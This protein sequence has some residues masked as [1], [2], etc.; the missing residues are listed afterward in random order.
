MGARSIFQMASQTPRHT[1]ESF[2]QP[3]ERPTV[4]WLCVHMP[5]GVNPDHLTMVG[6]LGAAVVF[7]GYLLSSRDPLFLWLANFGLILHWFGDSLDG[8][9]ARFR[10]IERPKYGYFLDHTTDVLGEVMI[11]LGLGLSSFVRFETACLALIVYLMLSILAFV[12]AQVSGVLEV[13]F[14][15]IGGTELRIGIFALNVLMFLAPP[16]PVL[17]LWAPLSLVDLGVLAAAAMGLVA[18]VI[19]LWQESRRLAREEPLPGRDPE[20]WNRT[21]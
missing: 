11:T 14:F 5:V 20:R 1:T 21:N 13:A 4:R 18:F 16:K 2:L 9:L 19:A 8:T 6:M 7:I 15:G 3:L 10:K 17:T 12:K